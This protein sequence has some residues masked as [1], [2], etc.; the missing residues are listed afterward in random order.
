MGENLHKLKLCYKFHMEYPMFIWSTYFSSI[1]VALFRDTPLGYLHWT[2]VG[3][4]I[5]VT[6]LA[7]WLSA[8]TS[9]CIQL[10]SRKLVYEPPVDSRGNPMNQTLYHC[11][12][13]D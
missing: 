9:K 8:Y 13:L 11:V 1:V 10:D 12:T 6:I 7:M 2:Q 4:Q 5:A 3:S